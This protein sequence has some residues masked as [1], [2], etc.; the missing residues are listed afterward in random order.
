M[1]FQNCTGRSKIVT[2]CKLCRIF[3]GLSKMVL[4]NIVAFA[5][6]RY[7]TISFPWKNLCF[8]ITAEVSKITKSVPCSLFFIFIE[9]SETAKSFVKIRLLFEIKNVAI[10][11]KTHFYWKRGCTKMLKHAKTFHTNK[12]YKLPIVAFIPNFPFSK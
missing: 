9:R 12:S 5:V 4:A 10:F 6:L 2:F 8:Q 11:I 7:C 3:W 1:V